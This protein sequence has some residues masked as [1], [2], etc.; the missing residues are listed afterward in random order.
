MKYIIEFNDEGGD[1]G[2]EDMEFILRARDFYFAIFDF[3][4]WLRAE[5][6]YKDKESIEILE[7]R[8]KL[9]E[10]L[11]DRKVSLDMLS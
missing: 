3:D 5:Y 1:Y 7:V 8:E 10:F 2:K 6:K 4:L 9:Y 11:Y